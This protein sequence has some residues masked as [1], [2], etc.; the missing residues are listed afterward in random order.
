MTDNGA[1][2]RV[3]RMAPFPIIQRGSDRHAGRTYQAL[4][5]RYLAMQ[6]QPLAIRATPIAPVILGVERIV[7]LDA[8]LTYA[9]TEDFPA[10]TLHAEG[11][12]VAPI[13]LPLRLLWVSA[14]GLPLY[15]ASD[16]HPI[17][18]WTAATAYWHK[19]YPMDRNEWTSHPNANTTAGRW[20][21]ARIPLVTR[22]PN[23]DAQLV[24]YVVG[25]ADEVRR[26]LNEY[27]TH[28]GRKPSTGYGRV[29]CWEVDVVD[30]PEEIAI[31]QILDR[32]NVPVDYYI[33]HGS[34]AEQTRLQRRMI[35]NRGWCP[36]YWHLP[37]AATVVAPER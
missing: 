17:G 18:T 29:G 6:M 25:N 5:E 12:G 13:P 20:K 9:V 15:A 19:R 35:P 34:L 1:G 37:Y 14:R 22:V 16:L 23:S 7:H 33:E 11:S 26:L 21:D 10:K 31:A 30:E 36:P 32:R 8:L 28:V 4:F 24:A 27:V 2:L 3:R